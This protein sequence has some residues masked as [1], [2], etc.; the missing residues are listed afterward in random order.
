MSGF[1]KLDTEAVAGGMTIATNR[2]ALKAIDTSKYQTVF[3]YEGGRTGIFVF[4]SGDYSAFVTADTMEGIYIKADDTASS[5]GAWVRSY[6]GR[7]SVK[8]FDAKG[9]NTA[10][11]LPSLQAA[12]DL[13][14]S[15][16]IPNGTYK[17][18]GPWLLDDNTVLE[19]ESWQAEINSTSATAILKA[20]GG[21]STRNFFIKIVSGT[22]RG[23]G[24][25]GPVGIDFTSTTYGIVQ[26]T[27][28]N[29]CSFG[30]LIGGSGSQGAFYNRVTDAII[31]EVTVGTRCGTLGNENI[32]RGVRVG[33]CQIGTDDDDN[34]CNTY[35][36]DA[37]EV[38]SASGHRV[39]NT[40]NASQRIRYI[41]PRL[42]NVGG[43]GVGIDIKAAAQSTIVSGEFYTGV[44]TGVQ[45]G[46]TG[47]DRVA[48]Y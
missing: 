38:F 40:G 48:A 23:S 22:L 24:T 32:F 11:D 16:F 9:D 25:G 47:T 18:N 1:W 36:A 42:E 46:G 37:I 35:D 17:T 44:A 12:T 5:S 14:D 20:R 21:S 7:A 8:W 10:A 2:T 6:S 13:C 27:F 45:D 3:L 30:I 19:F 39:C 43:V 41:N 34:T 29:K 26:N 28:I 33:S 4:R 15:V 31:T